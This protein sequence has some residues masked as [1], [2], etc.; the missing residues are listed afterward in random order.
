MTKW[1]SLIDD[2]VAKGAP[3]I[4]LHDCHN[5]CGSDFG[6]PTLALAPC[7]KSDIA[8]QWSLPLDGSYGALTSAQNGMCAGCV[9][10][11]DGGTPHAAS[12]F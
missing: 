3:P 4:V 1:R 5:G 10:V 9:S 12:Y 2:A 6:G 8:Q 7:D 11:D